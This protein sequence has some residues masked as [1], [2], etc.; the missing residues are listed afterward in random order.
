MQG[1]CFYCSK[2][3]GSSKGIVTNQ[4]DGV[5]FIEN[6]YIYTCKLALNNI[7]HVLYNGV[8]EGGL[9]TY[10]KGDKSCFSPFAH[11]SILLS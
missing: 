7:Q 6:E 4:F 9:D 8:S 1:P 3:Y 11:P 10:F 5:D 2:L